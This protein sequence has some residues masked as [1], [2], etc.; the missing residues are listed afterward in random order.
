MIPKN[1]PNCIKIHFDDWN[2]TGEKDLYIKKKNIKIK[3]VKDMA[4]KGNYKVAI[5]TF[6]Q[7]MNTTK[8]YS[9]ALFD[10][11]VNC[12][13]LVLCDTSTGYGVAKVLNILSQEEYEGKGVIPTKEIICKVDFTNFE[14]RKEL[15]KKKDSIKKQM[16]KMVK[17]NQELVLY[18]MLAEKNPEMATMLEEYKNLM[19]I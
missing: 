17:D 10:N 7:G 11:D 19:N 13:D 12:D 8:R 9:F 3:G 15:R 2:D 18:Q 6:L 1:Y 4:V 16:D 14:K 5:V